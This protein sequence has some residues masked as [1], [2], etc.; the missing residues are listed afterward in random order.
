M[1]VTRL[2]LTITALSLLAGCGV[3]RKLIAPKD[4]P[5]YEEK[6]RK[7]RKQL[8]IQTQEDIDAEKAVKAKTESAQ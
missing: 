8:E 6:Q 5:A 2:I 7:K 1:G 4:I 3:K